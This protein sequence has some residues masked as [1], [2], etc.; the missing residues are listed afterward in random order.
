MCR[1]ADLVLRKTV[2]DIPRDGYTVFHRHSSEYLHFHP[3]HRLA[4]P[5][6]RIS[7]AWLLSRI[8]TALIVAAA[9]FCYTYD[10]RR[11]VALFLVSFTVGLFVG[12]KT[13]P[14]NSS[15]VSV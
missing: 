6:R 7:E 11:F 1:A 14:L 4:Y 2:L 5:S 9:V 15:R 10:I 12:F 8:G 13:R 3:Q